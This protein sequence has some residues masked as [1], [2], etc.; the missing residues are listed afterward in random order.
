MGLGE[1]RP[2]TYTPGL[3]WWELVIPLD[4]LSHRWECWR[5]AIWQG[6]GSA[7]PFPRDTCGMA[8]LGR[9]LR[10]N[11]A[12]KIKYQ[13]GVGLLLAEKTGARGQSLHGRCFMG[14]PDWQNAAHLPYRSQHKS[15]ATPVPHKNTE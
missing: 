2:P 5:S 14:S 9:L 8:G 7:C 10:A 15:G 3:A 11:K 4:E 6:W 12:V 13:A 1:C